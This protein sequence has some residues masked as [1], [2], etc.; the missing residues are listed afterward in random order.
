M[1]YTIMIF[2]KH[3][4]NQDLIDYILRYPEKIFIKSFDIQGVKLDLFNKYRTLINRSSE[5]KI[6]NQTFIDTIRPFLTFYRSLPEYSKRTM[7]LTKSAIKFRDTISTA[8]DPEKIFFEDFPQAL[9]YSTVKLYESEKYLEDYILQLHN[10]IR[11]LRTCYDELVNRIE[12]Y[13]LKLTG[14]S[15]KSFVEYKKKMIQR[16]DS[17]KLKLLLPHQRIFYNRLI[18]ELNDRK[19]WINSLVYA[20]VDKNLDSINDDEEEIIYD[21]LDYI[22][23]ELDN[24]CEF[25]SMSIDKLT[26][27]AFKI[28]VNPLNES[29]KKE[30]VR[31][32]KKQIKELGSLEKT[33]RKELYK[34]KNKKLRKYLLVKLLNEEFSSD[35]N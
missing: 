15:N 31:L 6:T 23:K 3:L 1:L 33:F 20:V 27:E 22:F 19:S 26:E 24:L 17:I 12:D 28:E 29:L 25:A 2:F 32:P 18:S 30:I 11:E 5:G 8:K 34:T 35:Q 7:R 10:N 9:G 13:L 4:L 14:L 21:K 16:F